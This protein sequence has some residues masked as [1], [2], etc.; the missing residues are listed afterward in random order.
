LHPACDA[1]SQLISSIIRK[2]TVRLLQVFECLP[3]AE[4]NNRVMNACISVNVYDRRTV[5]LAVIFRSPEAMQE[6]L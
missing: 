4:N 3:N 6:N 2:K 5:G 1:S